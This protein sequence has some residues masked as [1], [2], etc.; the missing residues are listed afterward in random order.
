MSN[1]ADGVTLGTITVTL[2]TVKRL[3]T[4]AT[5]AMTTVKRAVALGVTN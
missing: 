4:G 3:S 5:V 1:L 2:W